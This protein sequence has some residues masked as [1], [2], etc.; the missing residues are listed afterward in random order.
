MSGR[1]GFGHEFILEARNEA[2]SRKII[3]FISTLRKN[4]TEERQTVTPFGYSP[5]ITGLQKAGFP[6]SV[7]RKAETRYFSLQDLN[8]YPVR[9][10]IDWRNI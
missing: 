10:N 5:N 4:L 8:K 2:L 1:R 6:F 9:T 7:A 3:Y